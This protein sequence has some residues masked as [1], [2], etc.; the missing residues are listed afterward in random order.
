MKGSVNKLYKSNSTERELER[1]KE[2]ESERE[3]RTQNSEH[4]ITTSNMILGIA[5]FK[6]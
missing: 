3:F 4:F 5:S 2:R 6:D 1:E